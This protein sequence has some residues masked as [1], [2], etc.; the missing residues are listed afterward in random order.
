LLARSLEISLGVSRWVA[1]AHRRLM[2]NSTRLS[3]LTGPGRVN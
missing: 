2:L 3:T 1:E